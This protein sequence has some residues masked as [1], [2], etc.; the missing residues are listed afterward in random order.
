MRDRSLFGVGKQSNRFIQSR[1]RIRNV[2]TRTGKIDW[3]QGQGSEDKINIRQEIVCFD[4]NDYD[5][6][7]VFARCSW[8][9]RN[10]QHTYCFDGRFS[11]LLF[12][13]VDIPN[14]EARLLQEYQGFAQNKLIK[15]PRLLQLE[16][17][18]QFTPKES[19]LLLI[20]LSQ[21]ENLSLPAGVRIADILEDIDEGDW[22]SIPSIEEI[23]ES[24]S[25]PVQD[26]LHTVKIKLF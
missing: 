18:R 13:Y 23:K 24:V 20:D 14:E 25:D 15:K 9:S 3:P 16:I 26:I 8:Q 21:Y 12:Y 7:I 10:F 2:I 4:M 11:K 22:S 1:I 19:R 17:D 5:Q 6:A